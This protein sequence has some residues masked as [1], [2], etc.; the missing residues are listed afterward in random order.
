MLETIWGR[1]LV[2]SRVS[3]ALYAGLKCA[4]FCYLGGLLALSH[5]T[6]GWARHVSLPSLANI[7][8]VLTDLAV[9]TCLLRAVPVLWEGWRF[10]T[11]EKP[12]SENLVNRE[13]NPGLESR[14]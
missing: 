9:A 8:Q 3:R 1:L 7:G 5:V 11:V 6:V 2:A 12:A 13:G 10:L 4:C 14:R